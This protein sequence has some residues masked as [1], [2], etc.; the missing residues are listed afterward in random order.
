[1]PRKTSSER[2]AIQ[3]PRDVITAPSLYDR[4]AAGLL[5]VVVVLVNA[6]LVSYEF[7]PVLVNPGFQSNAGSF[8]PYVSAANVI[9]AV[10]SLLLVIQNKSL[11]LISLVIPIL[12]GL[13]IYAW[14][15]GVRA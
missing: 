3:S 1:M 9:V 8:V 15:A 14:Y 5:L 7:L 6:R 10:I 2:E 13:T 11:R 4:I 12:I